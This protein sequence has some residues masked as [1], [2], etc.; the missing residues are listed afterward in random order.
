M[1]KPK[2]LQ[3]ETNDALAGMARENMTLKRELGIYRDYIEE[4]LRGDEDAYYRYIVGFRLL[5]GEDPP[6]SPPQPQEDD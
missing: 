6:T 2:S 4:S 5:H 3:A 1:A